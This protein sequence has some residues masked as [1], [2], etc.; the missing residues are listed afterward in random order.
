MTIDNHPAERLAIARVDAQLPVRLATLPGPQKRGT[1][2]TLNVV[3]EFSRGP[4]PPAMSWISGLAQTLELHRR[5]R[6]TQQGR[7]PKSGLL[8]TTMKLR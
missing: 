7:P 4:G 8:E 6:H 5:T 1:G 2:G 3:L